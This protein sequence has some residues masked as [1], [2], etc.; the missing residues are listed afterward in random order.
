MHVGGD[1]KLGIEFAWPKYEPHRLNF[2]YLSYQ[3][4]SVSM[5]LNSDSSSA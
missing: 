5:I 3:L 2:H 1:N 4:G